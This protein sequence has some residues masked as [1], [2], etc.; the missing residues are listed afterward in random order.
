MTGLGFFSASQSVHDEWWNTSI[1]SRFLITCLDWCYFLRDECLSREHWNP[2]DLL[3]VLP[4]PSFRPLLL[5]L[6]YL[7]L[8]S[9]NL[10]YNQCDFENLLLSISSSLLPQIYWLWLCSPPDAHYVVLHQSTPRLGGSNCMSCFANKT[11]KAHWEKRQT[12][13]HRVLCYI[14][15]TR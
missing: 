1:I 13:R 8:L 2:A 9:H 6:V 11:C 4:R 5:I 3:Y 10:D 12:D 7:F 14:C 15:L